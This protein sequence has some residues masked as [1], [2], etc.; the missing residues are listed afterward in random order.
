MRRILVIGIGAGNPEHVTVQAVAALNQT[1][2]FFLVDKGA[3]K[4]SLIAVRKEICER[5]IVDKAGYRLVEIPDPPRDRGAAAYQG[6]VED[7]HERRAEVFERAIDEHLTGDGCGAFLVWGD[8]MLY[9]STLRVIDRMLARGVVDFDVD[10]IPG[11]TS[12]Q[13]LASAHRLPI[14]RIGEP[15]LITTGRRLAAGLPQGLDSAVVMLDAGL[16]CKDFDDR[17]L[18][19]YWGAYLGTPDEVLMSGRLVDVAA[20]IDR[21]KRDLRSRHGWIMDTYLLRREWPARG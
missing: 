6:A 14:N 11:I 19:I 12:V 7:W 1:E 21:T 2:V 3:D 4:D 13:V 10:V 17:D 15:V 9:D 5:Y 8:P 20:A 16:S 18:Y